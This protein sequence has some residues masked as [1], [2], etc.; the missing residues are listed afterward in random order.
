MAMH[1]RVENWMCHE[2]LDVEFESPVA[3]VVS[4][5]MAGKSALRDAIE[6]A[7]AGTGQLGPQC[8]SLHSS[9]DQLFI[10]L[11]RSTQVALDGVILIHQATQQRPVGHEDCLFAHPDNL[12]DA[13]VALHYSR[14]TLQPAFA[15]W[16]VHLTGV[17]Q[18]AGEA[19]HEGQM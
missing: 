19:Q 14:L 8:T 17:M 4:R 7:V 10:R 11:T 6:F 18:H 16:L 12:R 9:G 13:P 15:E 2:R 3:L 1:L 5:N